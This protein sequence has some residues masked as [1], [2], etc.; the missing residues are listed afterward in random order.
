MEDRIEQ[1][2][3]ILNKYNQGHVIQLIEKH[4]GS[5]QEEILNQILSIDFDELDELYKRAAESVEIDTSTLEPIT[6]IF[7]EMLS[8]EERKSYVAARRA[9]NQR[10]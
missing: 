1:A 2:K 6:A 3:K 7:S 10:Q 8:E 5:M 9:S 4:S